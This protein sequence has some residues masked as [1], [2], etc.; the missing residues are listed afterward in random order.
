MS[1]AALLFNVAA[2]SRDAELPVFH[3]IT[4]EKI[5][6]KL[7]SLNANSHIAET[8]KKSVSEGLARE[9]FAKGGKSF[10][11]KSDNTKAAESHLNHS[12]LIN[13]NIR[14]LSTMDK[15][16]ACR[17]LLDS[18]CDWVSAAMLSVDPDSY[19]NVA[20]MF[21]S[22]VNKNMSA[23]GRN[24]HA[25]SP[26]MRDVVML[27]VE[28]CHFIA[29]QLEEQSKSFSMRAVFDSIKQSQIAR[30][31]ENS[32]S[33]SNKLKKIEEVWD[34]FEDSFYDIAQSA[35]Q[36]I[37]E[38]VAQFYKFTSADKKDQFVSFCTKNDK[39]LGRVLAQKVSD[40]ET[41]QGLLF[42]AASDSS[43][44]SAKGKGGKASDPSKKGEGAG[45]KM[46]WIIGAVVIVVLLAVVFFFI[47]KS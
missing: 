32:S 16:N 23:V 42:L 33:S 41:A 29:V 34:E 4:S 15:K 17:T 30:Y 6:G 43:S 24:G 44:P 25:E 3:S 11:S 46:M 21:M 31:D 36:I 35:Y 12:A 7:D 27:V 40:K 14:L 22:V 20:T 26:L 38:R 37:F 13:N 10:K 2:A 19:S 9:M 28:R 8:V 39:E 5:T 18:V 47:S 45:S 1:L